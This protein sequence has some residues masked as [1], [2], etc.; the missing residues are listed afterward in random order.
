MQIR[1]H[2]SRAAGNNS[3]T[4]PERDAILMLLIAKDRLIHRHHIPGLAGPESNNRSLVI[5]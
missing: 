5:G 4:S 2:V 1:L 3:L